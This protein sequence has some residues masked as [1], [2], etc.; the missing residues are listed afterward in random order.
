MVYHLSDNKKEL[1]VTTMEKLD[2]NLGYL[3]INSGL[4]KTRIS[5]SFRNRKTYKPADPKLILSFIP[6]TIIDIMVK[7]GQR[8]KKGEELMILDAM[9]M[10]NKLKSSMDG[11]IRK[12]CVEKGAR[13]PKGVVL[14]E[15][16]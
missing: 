16:A 14:I 8:V 13:V 7:E 12:I 10:K 11:K 5:N 9:K 15:L 2:N 6:G 3:N 4:Y 1:K